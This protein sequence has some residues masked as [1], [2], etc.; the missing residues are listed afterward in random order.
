MSVSTV[1]ASTTRVRDEAGLTG[2][3]NILDTKIDGYIVQAHSIVL[4]YLNAAYTSTLFTT[5]NAK[6]VWS[7][8][9]DYLTRAEELIAAGYLLWKE[10]GVNDLDETKKEWI[11]KVNEWKWLLQLLSDKN[12][13]ISLSDSDGTNFER[14]SIA[15]A[16]VMVSGA[17][18]DETAIFTRKMKF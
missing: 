5:D 17:D 1:Y 15:N 6:F 4:W 12:N 14:K 3:T 8:A 18:P 16:G 2:N 11:K 9:Q 13:P 7:Q 10:F